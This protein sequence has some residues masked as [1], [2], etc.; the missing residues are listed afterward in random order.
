[1]WN[2]IRMNT[3]QSFSPYMNISRPSVGYNH[4]WISV[5]WGDSST[6]YNHL[7]IFTFSVT[8]I[9][10]SHSRCTGLSL[11]NRQ[12]TTNYSRI[13]TV[14]GQ[15]DLSHL[16]TLLLGFTLDFTLPW[17]TTWFWYHG[18]GLRTPPMILT[19]VRSITSSIHDKK[20]QIREE[21][22]EQRGIA[23]WEKKNPP[24]ERVDIILNLIERS[25]TIDTL[26]DVTICLLSP[27]KQK[28]N[29]VVAQFLSC[30][31]F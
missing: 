2:Y 15:S 21:E 31:I 7:W 20:S 11:N 26:N 3:Q 14:C 1:M 29:L 25:K 16:S 19:A 4:S 8:I 17:A 22:E 18:W 9:H 13:S 27:F 30:K 12:Q 23:A 5:V 10:R 24:T 28:I 6:G